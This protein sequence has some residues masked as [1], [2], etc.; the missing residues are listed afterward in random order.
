M[1]KIRKV[2]TKIYGAANV[3]FT[4]QAESKLEQFSQWGY[5]KLPVCIAKTQYSFTDDPKLPWRS[6]RLDTAYFRRGAFGGSEV[7]RDHFRQH[8]ADAGPSETIASA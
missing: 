4:D 8:G 7:C 6:D 2:A 3:S 5:A 1:E